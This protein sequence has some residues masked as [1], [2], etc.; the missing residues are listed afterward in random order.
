M[1][2]LP[3]SDEVLVCTSETTSEEVI[4]SVT[5]LY[6]NTRVALAKGRT[7]NLVTHTDP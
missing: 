5:S 7:S 6:T 1:H 2:S 4:T 3:N